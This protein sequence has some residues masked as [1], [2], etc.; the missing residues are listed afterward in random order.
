MKAEK[1]LLTTTP[2]Y[3]LYEVMTNL[4]CA[5]DHTVSLVDIVSEELQFG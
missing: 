1:V 4:H 5:F 3:P 2:L